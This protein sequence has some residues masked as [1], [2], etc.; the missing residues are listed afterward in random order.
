MSIPLSNLVEPLSIL[1]IN[2]DRI[3]RNYLALQ[4]R[5]A[6]GCDCAAVVKADCYGLGAAAIV[7]ELY[8]ANCRHFYV[9]HASEGFA[10]RAALKG[11]EETQPAHIYAFH[12]SGGVAAEELLEQGIIPVLNSYGDI[13]QW[14]AL[15]AQKN[16]KLSAVIHID[17]GM[18][19]LGLPAAEV[20]KLA[21]NHDLLKRIDV[22]YVMSHL[23]CGDEAQ[24][25]KN[26]EQL[27]F[28]NRRV[29]RLGFPCRLSFANSS[30]IFLG[31]NY[32]F[33]QVRP[34][35][36]LYGINPQSGQ[37][38]PMD[39]VVT[40]KA[41]ILQIKE[42]PAEETVGYAASYRL[43][44]AMKL[45]TISAG[46]ADGILRSTGENGM[47]L[48]AGQKCPLVGRVSMD[49]II[50][51]VTQV[52]AGVAVGDWAE[53]IGPHQLVDDL[54]AQ[55]KTIGYEILTSLG[56]RYT[57]TYTGQDAQ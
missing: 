56:K 42:A 17:T 1:E 28:F 4:K 33:D 38:N 49:T 23:A 5:L 25:P 13:E 26:Q 19:R 7:P 6:R 10:V 32:H 18:N 27:T 9:A 15:A 35:C 48:I 14:A 53:I 45:A 16:Q 22:R 3:H 44:S 41:R 11:V 50:A 2:L 31:S 20:D 12:G 52:K 54:A 36:A 37:K 24:H 29:A 55:A 51:D 8:K 21:E 40:L 57:R 46:Y 39:G 47:V 34:G 30:G 43:S